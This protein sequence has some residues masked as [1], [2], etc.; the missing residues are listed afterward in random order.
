MAAPEADITTIEE[1]QT[2]QLSRKKRWSEP[3][4]DMEPSDISEVLRTELFRRICPDYESARKV[5][6][7]SFGTDVS[8]YGILQNDTRIHTYEEGEIVVRKGDYGNSAFFL[9]DGALALIFSPDLPPSVLGQRESRKEGF[10]SSI[11][12]NLKTYMSPSAPEYQWAPKDEEE[13]VEGKGVLP[14]PYFSEIKEPSKYETGPIK[15]GAIFGEVSAIYRTPR[16]ATIIASCESRVLEIRWQ[17][18]RDLMDADE[19][20]AGHID[21]LY[22]QHT[23]AGALERD[24]LFQDIPADQYNLVTFQTYGKFEEWSSDFIDFS[25]EEKHAAIEEEEVIAEEGDYP[26]GAYIV[27]TGFARVCTRYGKGH[28]TLSYIGTGRIFGLSEAIHNWKNPENPIPLQSGL[29][30]IGYV[31][32]LH[33]PTP[34][35]ENY[36]LPKIEADPS[37]VKDDI[38]ITKEDGLRGANT[39]S[40]RKEIGDDIFEFLAQ[41][42]FMNGT[43]TMVIDTHKCTRCDDCVRACS[44]AHDGNPRFQRQGPISGHHMIVN[45][46][47]HCADPVCMIGCP[48]GAIHRENLGGQVVVNQNTCIGCSTCYNN[49][50]YDAIRMVTVRDK[51]GFF[52]IS[53]SGDNKGTPIYKAT[54]CD[55]CVDHRGGPSCVRACPHGAL[56]RVDMQDTKSI[57]KI[58]SQ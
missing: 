33:I 20:T 39:D 9:M 13:I 42:R 18:L 51:K 57:K 11:A 38:Q 56:E 19:Q 34:L 10:L 53:A 49:C 32:V 27:R 26:D 40:V 54:K 30:A 29:R 45:S 16:S 25:V 3:F 24:P 36:V 48:T 47:M 46:C 1:D 2:G 50:P 55:L 7:Q 15:S 52:K 35:M 21:D 58:I 41:N 4:G 6:F 44:T 22:R 37:R 31:H 28:K 14:E 8:I 43:K 17:G 12:N 23:L 5:L